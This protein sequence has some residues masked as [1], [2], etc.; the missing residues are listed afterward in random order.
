[1][2]TART[3]LL[4]L[5]HECGAGKSIGP[6]EVARALDPQN[7]RARLDDVCHAAQRMVARRDIVVTEEGPDGDDASNGDDSP[8]VRY[9]LADKVLA[10]DAYRGIDFRKRPELYRVGRGEQGVLTA[11]PYKSELLPLWRFRTPDVAR[12]SSE[13]LVTAFERYRDARDYVGMDMAR[14]YLQMG[15]TRSRRYANHP[16]G[17]KYGD[18]G[19]VLPR[20]DEPVKA[21]C[22]GIFYDA[23][24]KVAR[25]S[26]YK[27]WRCVQ[28]AGGAAK[29]RRAPSTKDEDASG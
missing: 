3:E 11:E 2:P 20:A 21:Q 8:S 27:A 10:I 1:M 24:Q 22:A 6:S 13:A 19:E 17:K 25:D 18:D 15:Y 16:S 29:K 9:R 14:K 23:W 28:G 5:L 7:W 12:E 26:V 4:R